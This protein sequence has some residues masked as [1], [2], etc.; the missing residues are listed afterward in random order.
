[1]EI[2]IESY[3]VSPCI[4]NELATINPTTPILEHANTL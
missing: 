2:E 4:Y 1:M 3:L